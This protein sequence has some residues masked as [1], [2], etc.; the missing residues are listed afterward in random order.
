MKILALQC[1]E[2]EVFKRYLEGHDVRCPNDADDDFLEEVDIVLAHSWK[3][4][5]KL[6]PKMKKL[7][8]IQVFSAGV[9]HF[10]FSKIPENVVVCSNAGSNSWGVAEHALALIF[11]ALKH[12]VYRHNEMLRGNFPQMLPSKLLRGK[13]VGLIGL[14]NIA[15]D[16]SSMLR[17]FHV[18]LLGVSRSGR[19]SFCKDFIFV[20]KMDQLDF[21]LANSDIIV[22]ALPLT[23]E[24]MG[25]IDGKKLKMMKEDA[26]LVNVSRGRIIVEKD[27]YE[28]LKNHPNFTAAIDAWWHYGEGFRQNYPFEKLPNVILSPHCAGSYEGFWKDLTIS[29][30]ENIKKFIAGT[31]KNVVRREDYLD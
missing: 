27:L 25:L 1:R 9:D 30:A 2:F 13:N 21:L 4:L 22:L 29:A 19:C 24:T 14:G 18:N 17:C 26:I 15:R 3:K 7:K 11:A 23:R 12:T 28:H 20:G 16:L 31:P 10:D 8:M 6:L 5:E